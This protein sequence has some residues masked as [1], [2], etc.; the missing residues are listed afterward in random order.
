M[1]LGMIDIYR[2]FKSNNKDIKID[3]VEFRN[4]I[5]NYLQHVTST[6]INGKAVRLPG[7]M[8]S[9]TVVGKK[10]KPKIDKETGEIIGLSPDW[11]ATWKLWNAK[12]EAKEKKE[13]IYFLNEHSDFVRYKFQWSKRN[14][15]CE[16]KNYYSLQI[17]WAG[18]RKLASTIKQGKEYFIN[19][20][21]YK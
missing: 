7:K 3:R 10:I 17:C 6:V 20:K 15:Y 21:Q 5:S 4:L 19:H 2:Y 8:G 9:L 18:K 13:K 16:N 1:S 14:I 12:P 11:A